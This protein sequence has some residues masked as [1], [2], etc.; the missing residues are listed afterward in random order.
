MGEMSIYTRERS[1]SPRL[2]VIS[3][4]HM[5]RLTCVQD[6]NNFGSMWE[7]TPRDGACHQSVIGLNGLTRVEGQEGD[8]LL[9]R[10]GT[11]VKE[12]PSWLVVNFMVIDEG[13]AFA[14]MQAFTSLPFCLLI[15]LCFTITYF[16]QFL[17]LV[18]ILYLQTIDFWTR[19]GFSKGQSSMRILL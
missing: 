18:L 6:P 10:I 8:Q 15:E 5:V 19:Y 17:F 7:D 13:E 11:T 3:I 12:E 16:V 1:S 2:W 9:P 4:K 14:N